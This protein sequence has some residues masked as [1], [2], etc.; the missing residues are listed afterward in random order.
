METCE[1]AQLL[2]QCATKTSEAS[3]NELIRRFGRRLELGVRRGLRR[4]GLPA[5]PDRVEELLQEVYC[6]LLER[7]GRALARFQGVSEG[8]ASAY[9]GRLAENVVLDWVRSSVAQKR[10]AQTVAE[11]EIAVRGLRAAGPSPEEETLLGECRRI[12]LARCREAAGRR[13]ARQL[14]VLRLALLEGWSSREIAAAARGRLR[15]G[16]I[17]SLVARVRRRL[18]AEGC[19]LPRR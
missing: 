15:P 18:A 16:S 9:L 14:W 4:A 1:A 19:A 2:R 5:P 3:W 17:D 8:E 6:R 7:G 12:L 10:A 13:A 11:P